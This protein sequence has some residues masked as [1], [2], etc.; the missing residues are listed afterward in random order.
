M[1]IAKINER[2]EGNR[3]NITG[4]YIH[5]SA[6]ESYVDVSILDTYG[7]PMWKGAI[8]YQYRRT[9]IWFSTEQEVADYLIQI[10]DHFEPANVQEW[11]ANERRYWDENFLPKAGVST[12]I[13][14]QLLCM[15]WVHSEQFPQNPNLQRRIQY[16]KEKGYTLA[17]KPVKLDDNKSMKRKLL[18]LP[19][20]ASHGYERI[21]RR[22]RKR[23]LETLN[24]EN[25]YELS[26]A[27]RE[28]LFIDHKF[29]EQRWDAETPR[30]NPDDMP[31][32]T[33]RSKFQLL[34]N[35]R[36]Q[37]KR[38]VCRPCFQTGERGT[39][40]GINFFYAGGNRW[41][42]A[43]PQSGIVAEQGCVGCGW[44]DIQAWRQALNN[45]IGNTPE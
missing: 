38:E 1:N 41:D 2:L 13:F 19:R 42:D 29:P 22:L 12:P 23:I 17:S 34:D 32:D 20:Q 4:S 31:A 28:G 11:V 44:Y 18:P 33:I 8:P 25:V 16:V 5:T 36:N 35:Q 30:N 14:R 26:N 15:E 6:S 45:R 39:L 37:Q 27:N 24:A 7:T 40:F 10:R 21:S 43:I 3:I 9:G